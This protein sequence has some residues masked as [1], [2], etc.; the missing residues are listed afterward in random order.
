MEVIINNE[1]NFTITA[2]FQ[3]AF[4]WSVSAILGFFVPKL[5]F[6]F[7]IYFFLGTEQEVNK[8]HTCTHNLSP[9]KMCVCILIT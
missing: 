3:N 4:K 1:I 5:H 6:H 2:F 7:K 9:V 8:T